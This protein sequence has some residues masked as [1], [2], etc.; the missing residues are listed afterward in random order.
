MYNKIQNWYENEESTELSMEKIY[1]K[2]KL[3]SYISGGCGIKSSLLSGL[4]AS[5]V[6]Y[7]DRYMKKA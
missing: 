7:M 3:S 6:F 2:T 1:I 5:D 4:T